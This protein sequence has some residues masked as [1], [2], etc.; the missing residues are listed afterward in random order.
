M[1]VGALQFG[2]KAHSQAAETHVHAS[3]PLRTTSPLLYNCCVSG[4]VHVQDSRNM[5]VPDEKTTDGSVTKEEKNR[6]KL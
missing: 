2:S 3:Q 4:S 5:H 6:T 1:V